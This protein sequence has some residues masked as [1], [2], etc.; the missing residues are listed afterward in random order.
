M[1]SP[2]KIGIDKLSL[3]FKDDNSTNVAINEPK[4][5]VDEFRPKLNKKPIMQQKTK[6]AIEPVKVLRPILTKG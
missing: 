1:D 6:H 5:M 4:M 2:E 3:I